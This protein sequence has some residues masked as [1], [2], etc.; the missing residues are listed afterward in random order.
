MFFAAVPSF[1]NMKKR[2]HNY[3]A[4]EEEDVIFIC[5]PS[6]EPEADITWYINGNKLNCKSTVVIQNMHQVFF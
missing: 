5:D 1:E 3:N 4:T 2:P 6:A